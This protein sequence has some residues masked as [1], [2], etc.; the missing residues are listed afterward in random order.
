MHIE[1][2]VNPTTNRPNRMR[3]W[4]IRGRSII[5]ALLSENPPTAKDVSWSLLSDDGAYQELVET[6]DGDT[7]ETNFA[8]SIFEDALDWTLGL[9]VIGFIR[10]CVK[11]YKRYPRTFRVAV[12]HRGQVFILY[13]S[14]G[15]DAVLTWFKS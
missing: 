10:D 1:T 13:R 3:V 14:G 11:E 2:I 8:L 12:N 7:S 5:D 6:Q 4:T 9:A 15:K